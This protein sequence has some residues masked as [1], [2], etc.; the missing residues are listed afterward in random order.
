MNAIG[1]YFG[2]ELSKGREYH[3]NSILLNN[4]RN[5]I[6]Y[7]LKA[8]S[9]DHVFLPYF[10]CDAVLQPLNNLKIKHSF[11]YI[12]ENFEPIF[13]FELLGSKDVFIY[14]NY[15]GLKE[16]YIK[17]LQPIGNQLIIDN[18][19]AFFSK[20]LPNINTFYS[21]RKFFGVPDGAYLYS[22]NKILVKLQ[23]DYSSNRF[24]HLLK[25][26]DNSAEVGYQFFQDNENE[27]SQQPIKEMANLTQLMLQSI[28]YFKVAE[29][30]KNNFNF[31]NRE[32]GHFN[33]LKIKDLGSQTPFVYPLLL[34]N[35][36]KLR[37][38]LISQKIFTATYW[39]NVLN[40]MPRAS[41]EYNFAKNIIHLPIDQR[42]S[43]SDMRRVL[44]I[45]K[46]YL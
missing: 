2:L 27:L 10:T 38:E 19:Q 42:Y 7:V 5:A 22:N 40:E 14:T 8:N 30:R 41:L 15:F 28:N 39:Q 21:P 9:F 37:E 20:P 11:Y 26:L 45:V 18:A 3:K 36:I 43:L 25:R 32:I 31:L 23:K 46:K 4:G 1:G 24:E 35:T 12:D 29:L 13:N 33:R 34:K 17:K 6:E 44:R 16:N